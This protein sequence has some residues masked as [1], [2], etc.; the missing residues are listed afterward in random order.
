[1]IEVY[2]DNGNKAKFPDGKIVFD[3]TGDTANKLDIYKSIAV[4]NW[5]QVCF[6]RTVKE[7]EEED[8]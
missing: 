2:F 4:V 3:R 1:M 6:V 5:N 7:K 8:E